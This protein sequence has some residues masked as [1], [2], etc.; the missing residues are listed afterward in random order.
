MRGGRRGEA[1]GR[2]KAPGKTASRE[3][4]AETWVGEP[5]GRMSVF[6]R[7]N[8]EPIVL[9]VSVRQE[10]MAGRSSWVETNRLVSSAYMASLAG[11][12]ERTD[13]PEIARRRCMPRGSMAKSYRRQDKGSPWR[14]PRAR[15]KG[16]L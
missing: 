13:T 5:T 7:L 6:S 8:L 9:E 3:W 10:P 11:G 16:R 1:G 4:V 12:R 15:V 2:T 14:T